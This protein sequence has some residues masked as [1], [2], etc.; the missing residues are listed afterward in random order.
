MFNNSIKNDI[1]K[2]KYLIY[3][4]KYLSL[5]KNMIGGE[6]KELWLE[7]IDICKMKFMEIFKSKIDSIADFSSKSNSE[8]K[9]NLFIQDNEYITPQINSH[10]PLNKN[11]QLNVTNFTLH[12]NQKGDFLGR[13]WEVKT[14]VPISVKY[15]IINR[16]FI[17]DL[18]S[19]KI[20]IKFNY[21][22]DFKLI[23]INFFISIPLI[24]AQ[25]T[26]QIYEPLCDGMTPSYAYA[27]TPNDDDASHDAPYRMIS[28]MFTNDI[29]GWLGLGTE[30]N[31]TKNLGKY[32]KFNKNIPLRINY[33]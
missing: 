30:S 14:P 7:V 21:S 33:I 18:H 19:G 2:E 22:K 13:L 16:K 5:S 27:F 20:D 17:D 8:H 32:S 28:R 15:I 9:F 10:T 24:S 11:W 4:K 12:T 1:F 3:K 23:F 29:F 31:F 25:T 6:S 26:C